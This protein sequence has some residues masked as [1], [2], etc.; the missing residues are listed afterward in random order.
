METANFDIATPYLLFLGDVKEHLDAKTSNGVAEWRPELCVGQHRMPGCVPDLGLPELGFGE[1][2]EKGAKTL[3]IGVAR[4]GGI[5]PETWYPRLVEALEAGLDL[6]SG[7]HHRM[8]DVP[9]LRETAERLGRHL[10]DVRH[11]TREFDVGTAR[12]RTGKRLLTVGTDCSAGKMYTTL[13]LEREMKARGLPCDFRA[14][15]QT[16]IFIS[17]AGVCV[18]AVVAD[19]ISGAA[20]F[21]SPDN[22]PDHWDLVEGQGSLFHP[23]FAGVSLGLLHGS[24]PDA[25]VVCHEPNRAHVRGLP[26]WPVPSLK[27]CLE[28]NLYAARLTNPNV[29]CV[30]VSLVTKRMSEEDAADAIKQTEQELQLPCVDPARTGVG[31]LIDALSKL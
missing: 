8:A 18:D 12:K 26:H 16:G 14:T 21:L 7:L 1:S 3:L 13:A 15:G 6:A 27:T 4:S 23:S 2:V 5:L 31:P 24:Q 19:F 29:R 20:E 10:H 9:V 11:P 30:G 17:G 22:E 28:A 25:L